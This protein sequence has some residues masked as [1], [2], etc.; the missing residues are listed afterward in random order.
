MTARHAVSSPRKRGTHDH[1]PVVMGPGSPP[2]SAGVGRDDDHLVR[3]KDQLA[4][5]RNNRPLLSIVLYNEFCNSDV[6]AALRPRFPSRR[7]GRKVRCGS[8]CV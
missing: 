6:S 4:A 1:Q 3:V 5:V 2:A 7:C 8:I